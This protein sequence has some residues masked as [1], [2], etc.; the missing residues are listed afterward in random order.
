MDIVASLEHGRRIINAM[1]GKDDRSRLVARFAK[2]AFAETVER[3]VDTALMSGDPKALEP[4]VSNRERLAGLRSKTRRG[5]RDDT[6]D[7]LRRLTDAQ[8]TPGHMAAWLSGATKAQQPIRA[9]RVAER[10]KETL[11]PEEWSTLRQ[12][13]ADR[14]MQAMGP[15]ASASASADDFMKFLHGR[16]ERLMTVMFNR[17]ERDLMSRIGNTVRLQ[18]EAAAPAVKPLIARL[19][20]MISAPDKH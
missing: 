15:E 6:D 5:S 20:A 4:Y 9:V 10:L 17:N 14:V 12:A 2:E 13:T 19:G 1:E 18:G 16:G 8:A 7:I 3:T 11:K